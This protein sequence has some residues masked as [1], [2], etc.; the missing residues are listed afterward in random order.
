LTTRPDVVIRLPTADDNGQADYG[1]AR[2]ADLVRSLFA[3]ALELG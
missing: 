1:Y 2:L 3:A